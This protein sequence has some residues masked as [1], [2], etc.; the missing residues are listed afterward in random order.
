MSV[1]GI[2]DKRNLSEVLRVSPNSKGSDLQK[3]GAKLN[4]EGR[5]PFMVNNIATAL[6][7]YDTVFCIFGEGHFRDQRAVLDDMFGKEPDEYITEFPD[8]HTDFGKVKRNIFQR[9]IDIVKNK[10]HQMKIVRLVEF[11]KE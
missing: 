1:I 7:K 10:I 9:G 4:K 8:M 2:K 3:M 11:E 5:D 6:N